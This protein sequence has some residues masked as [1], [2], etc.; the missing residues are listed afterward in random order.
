M[1]YIRYA[2]LAL[3][4]VI[5]VSVA[6]AN[7]DPVTLELLPAAFAHAVGW[8]WSVTLPLF[9]VI[10]GGA[11]AGLI[12]GFVWEWI[13]E[14]KHRREVGRKRREV[15]RLEREVGR[16]ADEKHRGKDDVLAILDEADR[17]RA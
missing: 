3:I 13:R 15:K 12:F 7:R 8:N 14:H 11:A 2:I 10:L 5:I 1:R 4:A 6:M 16:L 17:R 9:L